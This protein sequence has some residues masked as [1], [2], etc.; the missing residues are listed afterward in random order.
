MILPALCLRSTSPVPPMPASFPHT[1]SP[2][3]S[4]SSPIAHLRPAS[5]DDYE[6][7]AAVEATAGLPPKSRRQWQSLWLGN[8][9]F[10]ELPAWPIG[11]VL[12]EPRGRIVGS[13]GNIPFLV[14]FGGRRY[15][16]ASACGWAV[17]PEYRASSFRLLA[18]QVRQ[19]VV[20]LHVTTTAN[21][22]ASALYARLGW[23][24]PPI[25]QW[26]RTA[27][28]VTGLVGLLHGSFFSRADSPG[29]PSPPPPPA[30]AASETSLRASS[31]THHISWARSFD[32]RFDEFWSG[33]LRR[34]PQSLLACRT[35]E[36]LEWHYQRALTQNRLRILTASAGSR[37]TAFAVFERR[38]S[39]SRGVSRVLL[40]DWQSLDIDPPL[41][42]AMFHF[43]LQCFRRERLQVLEN[44]GCWSEQLGFL[45]FPCLLHRKF[46]AWSYLYSASHPVL[47]A[48]LESPA[49]WHPTLY[50]GDASL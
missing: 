30:V 50:D 6:G 18:E 44:P 11:W 26:N 2:P 1:V 39:Q 31:A 42:S 32:A 21:E 43:A 8:P 41:C 38:D 36:T 10:R 49:A 19:P 37:L 16:A 5:L 20:D 29:Q 35:R 9:A 23:S 17:L 45:G 3:A 34:R 12:Q 27:V 28:W 15:V 7:I 13:I 14:H 46:R 4:P 40:V 47:R 22:I 48:A 25:G 33:L 24:R